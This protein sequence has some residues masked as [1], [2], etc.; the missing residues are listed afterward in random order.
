MPHQLEFWTT[1]QPPPPVATAWKDL[2]AEQRTAL[3]TVLARMIANAVYPQR[4]HENE[5]KDDER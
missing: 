4:T 1:E 2:D 5:E 3:I